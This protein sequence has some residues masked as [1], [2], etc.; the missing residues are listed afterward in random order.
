MWFECDN[1][2]VLLQHFEGMKFLIRRAAGYVNVA[3]VPKTDGS[4]I[5]IFR[6]VAF[7]VEDKTKFE[8][9]SCFCNAI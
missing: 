5:A 9:C 2:G 8:M 6:F 7:R 1:L 4:S 3:S